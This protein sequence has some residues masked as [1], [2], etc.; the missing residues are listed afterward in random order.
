MTTPGRLI[1]FSGPSGAGKTTLLRKLFTQA[2]QPLKMSVSATTRPP[3]PA[4]QDGVDYHFMTDEAFQE[5]RAAGDFLEC[6]EVFGYGFWYGTLRE[7]VAA[8]LESGQ[9]VVLEIDVQG[10]E[11][12]A[13]QFPEAITF[14][15]RP[16]SLT[17]LEQRLRDRGTES[18]ESIQRRLE[19]AKH[20]WPFGKQY[21]YEVINH[22]LDQAVGE[23]C[24]KLDSIGAQ[25]S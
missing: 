22:T 24:Q 16:D 7:S 12:V 1:I 14:F 23:I 10:R 15:V 17:I 13:E 5:R 3:R 8:S 21:T 9:W 6:V 25:T 19:V 18:E 11:K 20:E 4:E 2:E